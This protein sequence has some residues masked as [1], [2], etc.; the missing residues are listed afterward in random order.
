[1]AIKTSNNDNMKYASKRR[2]EAPP[3]D[4]RA[5]RFEDFYPRLG[6]GRTK[7]FAMVKSGEIRTISLGGRRLVPVS[8]FDR[9]LA[10]K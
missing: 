5:M 6:I 9:L 1:M 7:F 4:A 10:A 3:P 8:E 2:S